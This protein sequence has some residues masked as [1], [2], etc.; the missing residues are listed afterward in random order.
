MAT[1]FGN[2]DAFGTCTGRQAEL[3]AADTAVAKSRECRA[4]IQAG[5]RDRLVWA[6]HGAT[7]PTHWRHLRNG[8][9]LCPTGTSQPRRSARADQGTMVAAER[10]QH[11]FRLGDAGEPGEI[12]TLNQL[13]KSQLL[14]R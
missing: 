7:L 10:V 5:R 13:I 14:Y 11:E 9:A 2:A 6:R 8:D 12:R 4:L 3:H 1:L